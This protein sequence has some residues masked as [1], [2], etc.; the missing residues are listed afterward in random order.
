[1]LKKLIFRNNVFLVHTY[2]IFRHVRT[3][4]YNFF[5]NKKQQVNQLSE[6]VAVKKNFILFLCKLEFLQLYFET[7]DNK[8]PLYVLKF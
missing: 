7:T 5:F 6:H 1:M 2:I 4:S 3:A 8:Y